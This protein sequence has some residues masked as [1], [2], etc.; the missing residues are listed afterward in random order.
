MKLVRAARGIDVKLV[1]AARGIDVKLVR[2]ENAEPSG[3]ACALRV[4]GDAEN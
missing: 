4:R 3:G 1:R 2:A